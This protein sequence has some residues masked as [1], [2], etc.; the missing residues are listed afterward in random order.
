MHCIAV[1][2]P[3]IVLSG[4][5]IPCFGGN[6][7]SHSLL[8]ELLSGWQGGSLHSQQ[9]ILKLKTPSL[10]S[11]KGL[12]TWGSSCWSGALS[13]HGMSSSVSLLQIAAG[14]GDKMDSLKGYCCVC[15]LTSNP[16]L[17]AIFAEVVYEPVWHRVAAG[18]KVILQ[19]LA[20]FVLW[21]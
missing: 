9:H 4:W 5:V 3:C 13:V 8:Q 21:L 18:T 10:C 19:L 1:G 20:C 2:N 15:K 11:Q 16:D 14:G 17:K 12:D 6:N 7:R